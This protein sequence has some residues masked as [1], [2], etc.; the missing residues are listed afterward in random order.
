MCNMALIHSIVLEI[1]SGNEVCVKTYILIGHSTEP[2]VGQSSYYK[3][4]LD[5]PIGGVS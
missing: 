4:H 1:C 5:L 3:M 2:K